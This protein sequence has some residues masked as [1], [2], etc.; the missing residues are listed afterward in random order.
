MLQSLN[1]GKIFQI[2]KNVPFIGLIYRYQNLYT[3]AAWWTIAHEYSIL[4]AVLSL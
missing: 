4:L 3:Y 2:V 1:Y